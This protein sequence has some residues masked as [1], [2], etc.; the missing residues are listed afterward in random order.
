MKSSVCMDHD[1]SKA[2]PSQKFQEGGY[3]CIHYVFMYADI[4]I[5]LNIRQETIKLIRQQD[6]HNIPYVSRKIV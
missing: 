4:E 5:I 2:G 3:V 1:K 6:D